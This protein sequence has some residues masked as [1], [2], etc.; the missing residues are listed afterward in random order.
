MGP[1]P[2]SV[3]SKVWV[4]G[5]S[6]AGIADSNPAGDIGRLSLVS[7]V[8]LL[9]RGLCVGLITRPDESYREWCV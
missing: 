1:I 5:R 8:V 2:V 4:C 7:V 9:G 6:F 3:W